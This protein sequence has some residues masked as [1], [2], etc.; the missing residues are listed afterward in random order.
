MP[1]AKQVEAV[2]ARMKELNPGFDGNVTHV[3][4]GGVVKELEFKKLVMDI[5]PVRALPFLE[6]LTKLSFFG[7]RLVTLNTR[8]KVG[9][10]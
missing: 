7:K 10:R 5:S 9:S 1:P 4:E 3:V 6:P 8:S 2:A